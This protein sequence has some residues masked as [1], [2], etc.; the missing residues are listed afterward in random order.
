[1]FS[2]ILKKN[3]R[4][5]QAGVDENIESKR[6]KKMREGQKVSLSRANQAGNRG[7]NGSW[8]LM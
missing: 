4:E 6:S 1:M 7:D 2:F 5:E 8:D 3:Q